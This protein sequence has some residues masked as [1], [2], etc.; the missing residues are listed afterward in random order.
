MNYTRLICVELSTEP[1]E[2]CLM[3]LEAACSSAILRAPV[4]DIPLLTPVIISLM[5]S[6]TSPFRGTVDETPS[7]DAVCPLH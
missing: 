7:I 5:I 4:Y 3:K 2:V 6:L 1:A